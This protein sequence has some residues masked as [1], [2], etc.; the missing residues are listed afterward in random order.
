MFSNL[1]LCFLIVLL[2]ALAM[3]CAAQDHDRDAEKEKVIWQSLKAISPG[4][5][6]TFRAAT[7][8]LDRQDYKESARLYQ[9]VLMKAPEFDPA[10]RRLGDSLVELGPFDEGMVLLE[11]AVAK[12]SSAENL[13]TLAQYLAYPGEGR[14]ASKTNKERALSMA[15]RA[16]Q[17]AGDKDPSYVFLVAQLAL[18]LDRIDDFR[19]VMVTID[20]EYPD[21]MPTHYFNA[22]LATANEDW[23][24]AEDEIKTAQRLAFPQSLPR[25]SLLPVCARGLRSGVMRIIQSFW[26]PPGLSGWDSCSSRETCC[27]NKR[28]ARWS[29]LILTTL[30]PGRRAGSGN[31]IEI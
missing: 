19:A 10:L 4:S 2:A 29:N 14:T 30:P 25:R 16:S 24:K 13:I 18:D 26:W 1:R 11:K 23:A 7:A 12:N 8:A 3:T 6:E 5:V 20:R 27:P 9:Q 21:L 15:K 22:V 17:A 31:S 28:C